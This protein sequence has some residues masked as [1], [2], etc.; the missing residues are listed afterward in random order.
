M[1]LN[2]D[3]LSI[4]DLIKSRTPLIDL[5]SPI[6]FKKGAFP[7]S[8][9]IPILNDM[10]RTTVGITYK[11]EGGQAAAK[12]G[13]DLVKNQKDKIIHLWE[14]FIKNNPSTHIYCMRGGKRSQIAQLWLQDKGL[15]IPTVNGGYKALRRASIDILNSVSNDQKKW[16][17]LAGRTGTGK[18]TILRNLASSIDL[19]QHA[20]HKGSAFGGIQNEQPTPINFENTLASKYI[21]HSNNILFLEDESRK[22]GKLA[23]PNA[24]YIRMAESRVVI[25]ELD[26]EKRIENIAKEYV[27]SRLDNGMSKEDLNQL[28][29]S[30]LFKIRKRLGLKNYNEISREIYSILIDLN[31]ASHSGWIKELLVRYYDP[32]YDYQLESKK[33][34]CALKGN[35]SEVVNF[36]NKIEQ[37][38][39]L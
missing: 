27:Y 13:F 25:I 24:W 19:E 33:D 3:M 18:T 34:R 11:K 10:Q 36:L 12:I 32:M 35:K 14:E 4:T 8:T 37:N 15:N 2:H 29:Q 30:S 1:D 26:I 39:S 16:I 17:I 9:N 38:Q 7:S 20:S 22:I 31:K 6:E 5:R 28:L 21:Q 23:I